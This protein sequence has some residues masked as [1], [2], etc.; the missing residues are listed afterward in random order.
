[1]AEFC[2]DC[3]NRLNH[4]Q[5]TEWDWIISKELDL[6]EGCGQWKHVLVRPR[7]HKLLCDLTSWW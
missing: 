5:D 7:R 3:W 6:C 2:L 4:S 1:M